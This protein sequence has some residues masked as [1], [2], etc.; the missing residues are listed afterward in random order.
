VLR[1]EFH[2]I[3]SYWRTLEQQLLQVRD[4]CQLDQCLQPCIG[5]PVP[6]EVQQTKVSQIP[7]TKSPQP[8]ITYLGAFKHKM[9]DKL[10][11]GLAQNPETLISKFVVAEFQ[12]SD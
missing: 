10:Q 6:I 11:I 12:R 4:C 8:S 9:L 1:K 3:S 7:A 5:Y 2:P